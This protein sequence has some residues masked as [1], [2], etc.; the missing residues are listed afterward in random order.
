MKKI[1]I[2][3]LTI[4][5][6]A[7]AFCQQNNNPVSYEAKTDYLQKSKSKKT[8]AWLFLGG[9][10]ALAVAGVLIPKGDQTEYDYLTFSYTHKND[11][12]KFGLILG[13]ALSMGGSIPFFVASARNKRKAIAAAAFL[14]IKKIPALKQMQVSNLNYPVVGLRIAL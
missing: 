2:V 14:D 9:G 1:I 13:G 5:Y 10:V 11:N 4:I 7:T 12:L 8:I 3:S 6:A